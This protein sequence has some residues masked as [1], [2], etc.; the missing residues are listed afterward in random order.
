MTDFRGKLFWGANLAFI[1]W[2]LFIY[3]FSGILESLLGD[4]WFC[5]TV[6]VFFGI[7]IWWGTACISKDPQADRSAAEI[8][9][10]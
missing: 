2:G 4:F 6:G 5:A 10:G 7:F 9:A 3:F 8:E 1:A